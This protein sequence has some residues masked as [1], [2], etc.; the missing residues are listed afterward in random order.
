VRVFSVLPQFDEPSEHGF[1]PRASRGTAALQNHAKTAREAPAK[2]TKLVKIVTSV[3]IS[4]P[5]D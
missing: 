4:D 2:L 3:E 1:L 5:S